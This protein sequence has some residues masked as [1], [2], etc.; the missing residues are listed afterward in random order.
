ML[1]LELLDRNGF[2]EA[3]DQ[4]LAEPQ[5]EVEGVLRPLAGVDLHLEVF[6]EEVDDLT[7]RRAAAEWLALGV[8]RAAI[9]E[10]DRGELGTVL[11]EGSL[12]SSH[13]PK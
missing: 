3:G 10:H 11:A 6:E 2:A 13:F 4:L 9:A 7:E 8:V 12:G 1:R 5:V